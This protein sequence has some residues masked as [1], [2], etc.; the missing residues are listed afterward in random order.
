MLVLSRLLGQGLLQMT[1]PRSSWTPS[2]LNFTHI[3]LKFKPPHSVVNVDSGRQDWLHLLHMIASHRPPHL[4]S[5]YATILLQ[6]GDVLPVQSFPSMWEACHNAKY[7]VTAG[8]LP[9]TNSLP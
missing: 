6:V 7:R 5:D 9:T 2:H 4:Q 8:H 3:G 1:L